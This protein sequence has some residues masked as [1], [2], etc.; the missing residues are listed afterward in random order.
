MCN[1]NVLSFNKKK[2][3]K[4]CDDSDITE[5]KIRIGEVT[6]SEDHE[7]RLEN[8]RKTVL[9]GSLSTAFLIGGFSI[10]MP[11]TQA[12]RDELNCDALCQGS[13]TSFRSLLNLIGSVLLGRLSDGRI[14]GKS[15]RKVCLYI[16]AFGSSVDF[17]I[18]GSTFSINGIWWSVIFG[19]LLQHNFLIL[20]AMIAD[21]YE[22]IDQYL[23]SVKSSSTSSSAVRASS[24]GK[25]GMSVGLAFMVGP[26]IGGYFVKDFEHGILVALGFIFISVFFIYKIPNYDSHAKKKE[27]DEKE[28]SVKAIGASFFDFMKVKAAR[29]PAAVFLM[30]VRTLMGL[31]YHIFNT[32]W[33]ASLKRRFQFGPADYGRFFSF[34][35]LG[36]AL[37]QGFVA[38]RLVRAFGPKRR[39]LLISLCCI[40]LGAG[41][42]LAFHTQSIQVVYV[43]FFF[44]ITALGV[45]NTVI[46][47]DTSKI[48][49]SDEIGGL[50]GLLDAV[51]SASGIMGPI[52]G[53]VLGRISW[54]KDINST[55]SF[56]PLVAVV[57]TYGVILILVVTGYEKYVIN[58]EIT[59]KSPKETLIK[60]E[61]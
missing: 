23:I 24:I 6:R 61:N 60:K 9:Y 25:I 56:A 44:I 49:S 5:K 32:I 12:R 36:F 41:R 28:S 54:G 14:F 35:G 31:A 43:L 38:G 13:I 16:G 40:A 50:T 46:S 18:M 10:C 29:S 26:I 2:E 45:M 8:L 34:I 21:C 27:N 53:G 7:V 19:S 52:I 37:S 30:I 39:T 1:P 57:T 20:K 51:Q 22:N 3:H 11:Y 42:W 47:A 48:A 58:M 15:G 59:N 4:N 33:T 17:L 55:N